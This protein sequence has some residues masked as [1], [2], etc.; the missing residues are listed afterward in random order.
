MKER[1]KE[2]TKKRKNEWKK[3]KEGRKRK[4]RRRRIKEPKIHLR[5]DN[6]TT[7][8]KTKALAFKLHAVVSA[9]ATINPHA[10]RV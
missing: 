3:G 4:R 10:R 6:L 7:N 8:S 9:V 1:R 5:M 2:R